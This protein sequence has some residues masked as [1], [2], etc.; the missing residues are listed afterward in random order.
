MQ[1]MWNTRFAS[2]EYV[3]GE[4]PNIFL[5]EHLD[6]LLGCKKVLLIA[7]GEGRNAV[8]LARQG[9][10]VTAVDFSEVGRDKCLSLAS[11]YNVKVDYHVADLANYDFPSNTYDAV[12]GIFAHTPAFIRKSVHAQIPSALKQNGICLIKGYTPE[13]ITLGTGGPKDPE[14]MLST[15]I[16]TDE[17]I[18]LD[19]LYCE[20]KRVVLNEGIL[21]QGESAVIEFIAR[22]L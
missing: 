17:I 22:K 3:Y 7:E 15:C 9:L 18:G 20:E 8:Y 21:H 5:V 2:S 12:I 6:K 19:V 16:L 1:E 10:D 11:K 4:L 13:Q 14:M